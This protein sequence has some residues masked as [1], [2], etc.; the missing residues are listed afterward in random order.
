DAARRVVGRL[1]APVALRALHLGD[2][3][4]A[5][6]TLGGEGLGLLAVDLRPLRPRAPRRVALEER[7]LVARAALPVDPAE[8]ETGLD[9]L[10]CRDGRDA[11]ALLRDADPE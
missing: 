4:R 10:R 7:R 1:P 3:R 5:Q 9:G 11:R 2:P 6:P 8:A